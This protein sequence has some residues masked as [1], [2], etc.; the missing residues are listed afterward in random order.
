MDG[1]FQHGTPHKEWK[2][3]SMFV[4]YPHGIVQCYPKFMPPQQVQNGSRPQTPDYA[5]ENWKS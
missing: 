1:V 3:V 4:R 5:T 2:L